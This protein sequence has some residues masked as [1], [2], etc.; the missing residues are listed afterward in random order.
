MGVPQGSCLGPLLYLIA[1][2]EMPEAARMENCDNVAHENTKDLF[3]ST[4]EDCGSL[5]VYADDG[6]FMIAGKSR[7]NNQERINSSFRAIKTFLGANGLAV[8]DEKTALTEV[9]SKQKRGRLR[10]DPPHLDIQI[11]ENGVIVDKKIENKKVCRYLGINLQE[12][13]SWEAQISTG[14]KA[15]I[16]AIRRQI[17]S[18]YHHRNTIPWR[19][20][21]MIANA[22]IIGRLTYGISLWGGAAAKHIRKAQAVMNWG[23]RFVTRAPKR[24]RMV[25]LMVRCNWLNVK[26]LIL[27][28][29]LIQHWKV[30][31]WKIPSELWR[32]FVVDE[33]WDVQLNSPRLLLSKNVYLWR[34]GRQWNE[35]PTFLKDAN[36][37]SIFKKHLKIWIMEQRLQTPNTPP[38]P[39][40]NFDPDPDPEQE[41]GEDPDTVTRQD[42]DT[43]LDPDPDPDHDTTPGPGSK[44]RSTIP[45]PSPDPDP[46]PSPGPGPG[47][48]TDPSPDPGPG[49]RCDPCENIPPAPGQDT[50]ST[51]PTGPAPN[52]NLDK[53]LILSQLPIPYQ[54]SLSRPQSLDP[55]PGPGK[56]PSPDPDHDPDPDPDPDH[57]PDPGGATNHKNHIYPP[58]TSP[59]P[60]PMSLH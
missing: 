11:L 52:Q 31:K 3:G 49:P 34:I 41:P 55:D 22:I 32:E 2:N 59:P 57:S 14:K 51:T 36:R 35:L 18:L 5:P 48:D 33:N 23:A 58:T 50:V 29:S 46:S 9:M 24:T 19:S 12:N 47:L 4:C 54:R 21:L 15:I 40:L 1:M 16:P 26:E 53:F 8:N 43:T 45:D 38:G 44:S 56:D 25:E 39:D 20:R 30:L 7:L 27:Y 6:M 13:Q 60:P 37:I 10:G 17:G 28:H 42:P